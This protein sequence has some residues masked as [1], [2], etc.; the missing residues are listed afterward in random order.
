MVS[1]VAL[2][3]QSDKFLDIP[4]AIQSAKWVEVIAIVAFKAFTRIKPIF[5][6]H[7]FPQFA[8]LKPTF[9]GH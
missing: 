4:T 5:A 2:C 1:M 8:C 3:E 7:D 9:V 6:V